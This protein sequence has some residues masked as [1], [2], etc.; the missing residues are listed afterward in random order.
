MLLYDV[1]IRAYK[2]YLHGHS[3]QMRIE[4][5]E[6]ENVQRMPEKTTLNALDR[7]KITQRGMSTT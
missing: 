5:D 2:H 7:M 3:T 4:M 1:S 6:M